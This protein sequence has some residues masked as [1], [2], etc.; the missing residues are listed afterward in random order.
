MTKS[1][2]SSFKTYASLFEQPDL[3][4]MKESKNF[5]MLRAKLDNHLIN[6]KLRLFKNFDGIVKPISAEIVICKRIGSGS[7][8]QNDFKL[9]GQNW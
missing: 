2:N 1:Y 9:K 6:L 4:E 5:Q 7:E 3:N 8:R